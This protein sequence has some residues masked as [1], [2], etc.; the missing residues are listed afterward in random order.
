MQQSYKDWL[1]SIGIMEILPDGNV[2]THE[3][4]LSDKIQGFKA[5]ASTL[6]TRVGLN[7]ATV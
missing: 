1:I 2:V 3:C 5:A 4:C 7:Q 6:D